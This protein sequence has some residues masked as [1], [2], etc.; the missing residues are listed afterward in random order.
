MFENEVCCSGVF[1]WCYVDVPLLFRGVPLVFQGGLLLHHCSGVPLIGW[2]SVFRCSMFW[3]S[4]FYSMSSLS[5]IFDCS[6]RQVGFGRF[7]LSS[8]KENIKKLLLQSK[9]KYIKNAMATVIAQKS[10]KA[11]FQLW[12]LKKKDTLKLVN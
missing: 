7:I 1:Y 3:H 6:Y 10:S 12:S 5:S 2:C 11:F 4:W 9:Y 8:Y